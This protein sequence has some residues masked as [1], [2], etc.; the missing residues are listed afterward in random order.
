MPRIPLCLR[1]GDKTVEALG[2]VDSGATVNVLPDE[3]GI[4]LGG[5]WDDSRAIIQLAGNLSNMPAMPFFANVEIGNFA[6]VQLAFAWVR[7]ANV[8]LILGQTNFF[9]EFDVCFYRSKL[10]FEI[11]PKSE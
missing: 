4:E 5:V 10:E 8:P 11:E 7:R 6:P 1:Q 3:I 2:L 9:L